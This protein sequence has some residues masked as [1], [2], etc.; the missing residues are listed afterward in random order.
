R[1]VMRGIDQRQAPFSR[2]RS[3][4]CHEL[5]LLRK[6]RP[7]AATKLLPTLRVVSEPLA[8]LS[9]RG[10]LLH[11][12]S[13]V[14]IGLR[15]A[16]RPQSVD[17]DPG[18]IARPGRLVSPLDTHSRSCFG[19]AHR[20]LQGGRAS[21]YAC[22]LHL[23]ERVSNRYSIRTSTDLSGMHTQATIWPPGERPCSMASSAWRLSRPRKIVETVSV[24]PF[25]RN[26]SA[27]SRAAGSPCWSILSHAVACPT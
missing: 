16:A 14:G 25:L 21:S 3:Q 11:P 17:E 15:H 12:L 10:D 22:R 4:L 2:E 23:R 19:L 1:L 6:L 13:D 26:Q 18:A 7:I 9:A 24:R 8:Q 5:P 20:Y 27:T